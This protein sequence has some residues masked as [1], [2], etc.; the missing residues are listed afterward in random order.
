MAAFRLGEQVHME[1]FSRRPCPTFEPNRRL[2]AGLCLS[3][4]LEA[5]GGFELILRLL[6]PLTDPLGLGTIKTLFGVGKI[7]QGEAQNFPHKT[8]CIRPHAGPVCISPLQRSNIRRAW[9][10]LS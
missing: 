3:F 5:V 9:S 6:R 1:G 4:G 10:C 2:S 7:F 8:F